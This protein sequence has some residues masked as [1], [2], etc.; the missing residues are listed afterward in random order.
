MSTSKGL[1]GFRGV[2]HIG[3]TVPNFEEAR[4]FLV[5]V[6]GFEEFYLH[7]PYGSEE[8]DWMQDMLNVHPRAVIEKVQIFRAGHGPN[9]EL[10]EYSA[11]DQRQAMPQ[12]S[13]WGGHHITL[14]VDDIDAAMDHLRQHGVRLMN[15]GGP[16]GEQGPEAGLRSCY[17]LTPWDMQMELISF[18]GGKGYE[19]ETDRRLWD[20]R[21]PGA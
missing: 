20:V 18:P 16:A 21:N 1:P 13:D 10:F 12:N 9:I 4:D 17:F 11:P 8:T 2:D 14:Y 15:G 6:L 19:R 3:V 5:N 7:G